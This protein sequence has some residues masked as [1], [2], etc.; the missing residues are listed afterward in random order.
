MLASKAKALGRKRLRELGTIVTPDTLLRRYR[1]LVSTKYDR[2]ARR[3]P[4]ARKRD[5]IVGLVLRLGREDPTVARARR[6]SCVLTGAMSALRTSYAPDRRRT[7]PTLS[8][9]RARTEGPPG[10]RRDRYVLR[11]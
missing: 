8:R 6:R 2:S 11:V 9:R 7:R 10:A 4:G 3:G 5:E 1:R